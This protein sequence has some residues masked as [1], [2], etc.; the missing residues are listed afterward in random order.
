MR[1][2]IEV[3]SLLGIGGKSFQANKDIFLPNLETLEY[4]VP[5]FIIL[6]D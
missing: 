1:N 5:H 4:N 3:Q 2:E 6:L